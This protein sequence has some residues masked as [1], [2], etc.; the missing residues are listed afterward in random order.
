MCGNDLLVGHS[1]CGFR[2]GFCGI[3]LP[4]KNLFVFTQWKRWLRSHWRAFVVYL[5]WPLLNEH[6]QTW[7]GIGAICDIVIALVMPY[8]VS[9]VHPVV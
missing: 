5:R 7:N 1:L 2:F 8:F 4:R 6:F 9:T 3:L